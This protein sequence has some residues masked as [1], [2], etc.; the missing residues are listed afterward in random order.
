[1]FF[2]FIFAVYIYVTV[3][4]VNM[5]IEYNYKIV[6]ISLRIYIC[7][8]LEQTSRGL[9]VEVIDRLMQ[10]IYPMLATSMVGLNRI[11]I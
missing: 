10:K 3:L 8:F 11:R 6:N 4:V 7:H 9:S 2:I 5:R 1:M